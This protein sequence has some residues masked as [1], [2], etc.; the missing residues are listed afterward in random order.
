MLFYQHFVQFLFFFLAIHDLVVYL[1]YE[2]FLLLEF[3][4]GE[5]NHVCSPHSKV[6]WLEK[7][8]L[9]HHAHIYRI[10]DDV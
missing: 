6:K 3:D 9:R 1:P 7:I 8:C 10:P 5:N 2:K 4:D